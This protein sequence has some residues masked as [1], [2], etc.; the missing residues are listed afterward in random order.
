MAVHTTEGY[1]FVPQKCFGW[2]PQVCHTGALFKE[3]TF[4]CERGIITGYNRDTSSCELKRG[5]ITATTVMDVGDGSYVVSTLD[6][7]YT[8]SCK[9][10]HQERHRLGRGTHYVQVEEECVVTGSAWRLMGEIHQFINATAETSV[11]DVP[12]VDIESLMPP[13]WQEEM[14]NNNNTR[15]L[16]LH[17]D[18]N[19]NSMNNLMNHME[20][21]NDGYDE[22]F[23]GHSVA[24]GA[25]GIALI[26]LIL[27]SIVGR[28]IYAKRKKINYFL[29]DAKQPAK[30]P[31]AGISHAKPTEETEEIETTP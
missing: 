16:P 13:Y 18:F 17:N 1:W 20:D 6:D 4:K 8:T 5:S 21:M 12:T 30:P 31:R 10:Q 14:N 7:E 15:Y 28:Y 3:P 26:V 9:G 22:G 27:G 23:I 25:M 19:D 24:W 2:R 11:M 29:A